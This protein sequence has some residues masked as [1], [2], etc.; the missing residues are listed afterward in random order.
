MAGDSG[1]AY[2]SGVSARPLVSIVLPTYN[3]V[4]YLREA[5]ASVQ[6]QTYDHWELVVV[7]DGSTDGTHAFLESL[8]D[9]RVRAVRRA[10]DGNVALLRNVGARESRGAYFAL[11]DSDDT[12]LPE[13]LALQL[14]DLHARPECRWSY[15]GFTHVDE[16]GNGSPW[17]NRRP[18]S[19][20][21]GQIL[22]VVVAVQALIATSTVI[23]ERG[24]F[25]S[26]G[27]F[28][29][30]LLRCEDYGLWIRLAEESPASVVA[31]PLMNRRQHPA[32]RRTNPVDVL[33]YMHR[34][35][36]GLL[37]RS[38]S[39][40]IRRLCRRQRARASLRIA[41]QCRSAG[42]YAEARRALAISFVYAGW[43]PGWWSAV[44]KTWL[45]PTI[46]PPLLSLYSRLRT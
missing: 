13:K 9:A 3:R 45:R 10:H 33:R 39:S 8:G 34:I 26:V 35:Y 12:W 24:L 4:A 20:Y 30:S 37:A 1:G 27:G 31:M 32:D 44:I 41:R 2:N 18:W 7:D 42:R 40:R 43:H 22:D 38:A 6:A 5:V 15:T 21:G 11:L 14:E 23:V 19:A 25:Q 28:D 29:E 16:H 17:L 36:G 46:P